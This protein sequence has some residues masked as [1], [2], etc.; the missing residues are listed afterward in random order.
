MWSNH[1]APPRLR[2]RASQVRRARVLANYPMC[3]V[4]HRR[5][6]TIADHILNLAAGG[7]DTEDN[8]AGICKPCHNRKTSIESARAI[9]RISQPAARW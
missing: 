5:A 9:L 8:M 7:Q 1:N 6:S 3:Y 2:G 4:C